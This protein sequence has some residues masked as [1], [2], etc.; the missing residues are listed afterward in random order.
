MIEL[1]DPGS[2]T[3][4]IVAFVAR[5]R[6]RWWDWLYRGPYRHVV[7]FR[8]VPGRDLWVGLDWHSRGLTYHLMTRDKA[9]GTWIQIE[10]DGGKLIRWEGP[11]GPGASPV[12]PAYCVPAVAHAIGLGKWVITPGALIGALRRT[13]GE[14]FLTGVV[15]AQQECPDGRYSKPQSAQARS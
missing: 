12:W 1:A 10:Q 6:L 11:V 13:G 8:F 7:A 14:D 5:P 2:K 9:V 15:D 3:I 4:W